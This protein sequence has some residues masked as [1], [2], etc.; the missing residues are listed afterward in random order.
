MGD[1]LK[2]HSAR[3]TILKQGFFWAIATQFSPAFALDLKNASPTAVAG[4][5]LSADHKAALIPI[6]DTILP[7][8]DTPSAS[9]V[10]VVEFI[11]TMLVG[12]TSEEERDVFLD[13]LKE[14][15]SSTQKTFGRPFRNLSAEDRLGHLKTLQ[16][17][18]NH[19]GKKTPFPPFIS[20]IKGFTVYGYYTSED[21][22][23]GELS[24]NITPGYL[25]TCAHL[26]GND[27]APAI[28]RSNIVAFNVF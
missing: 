2:V 11:E 15:E 14:F 1:V 6:V 18:A 19:S 28:S 3:R 8:T 17:S 25:E 22:A 4:P 24:V 20:L 12:W 21:G 16:E 26:D 10:G 13:G 23:Y 5:V 9:Q 7:E 27:R